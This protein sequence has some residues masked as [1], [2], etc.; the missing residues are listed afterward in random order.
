L[1][2]DF[3][4]EILDSKEPFETTD[5]SNVDVEM[6]THQNEQIVSNIRKIMFGL[7]K[8]KLIFLVFIF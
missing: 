7:K 4:E 6:E 8:G 1:E 5:P 2:E 3:V